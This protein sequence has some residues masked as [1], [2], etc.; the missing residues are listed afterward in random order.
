M[1]YLEAPSADPDR[2]ADARRVSRLVGELPSKQREVVLLR[3]ALEMSSGTAA[4]AASS[5]S[6]GNAMQHRM[7]SNGQHRQLNLFIVLPH[8]QRRGV[9]TELVELLLQGVRAP[10][11]LGRSQCGNPVV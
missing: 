5:A 1:P 10:A 8:S 2:A 3:Q 4:G 7:V 9:T 6:T 11:Q